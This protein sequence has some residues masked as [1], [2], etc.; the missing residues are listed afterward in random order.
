MA[1]KRTKKHRAA[2]PAAPPR[3]TGEDARAEAIELLGTGIAA[4]EVAR[5]LGVQ[6]R[7]VRR[8]RDSPAGHARLTEIRRARAVTFE[9]LQNSLTHLGLE[10]APRALNRQGDLLD[11]RSESVRQKAATD[12]LDRF[13]PSRRERV[14][15]SDDGDDVDLSLLSDEDLARYEAAEAERRAILEKVRGAKGATGE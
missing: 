14:H 12:L 13:G 7:T 15:T 2:K 4:A 3:R 1:P 8:W 5:R 6:P 10:L 9:E 11:A